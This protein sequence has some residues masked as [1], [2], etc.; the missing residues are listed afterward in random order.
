MRGWATVT[1]LGLAAGLAGW[2]GGAE[3]EAL[4]ERYCLEC[5]NASEQKG[6]LDLGGTAAVWSD[7]E[8]LENLEWVIAE[9]EMP[10][11]RS[12]QPTE[13][14]RAILGGWI[15]EKLAE[16]EEATKGDPGL[17]IMP[18]LNQA[19]YN[20]VIRD[21]TGHDLKPARFFPADQVAENGYA[22]M[23]AVL[24]VSPVHAENYLSAAKWV[25]EHALISPVRGVVWHPN[26]LETGSAEQIRETLLEEWYAWLAG[27]EA[28]QFGQGVSDG[29]DPDA[30]NV[31]EYLLAAWKYRFREE[32]GRPGWNFETL[33]EEAEGTMS[34][35]ILERWFGV[36]SESEEGLV[37]NYA[38]AWR[39]I[40]G[41]AAGD[42]GQAAE[43]C[44]VLEE[45]LLANLHPI[46]T[47]AWYQIGRVP[48][49]FRPEWEASQPNEPT[50]RP[51]ARYRSNGFPDWATDLLKRARYAADLDLEAFGGETLFLTV[52]DAWDG[53]AGDRVQLGDPRIE[54]ENGEVVSWA[55]AGLDVEWLRGGGA[56][57]ARIE[58]GAWL[59][60]PLV[61]R[62]ALP[63]G[64]RRLHAT[65]QLSDEKKR[66]ASVQ[67]VFTE[68]APEA[69]QQLYYPQRQ[70]LAWPENRKA[71]LESVQ[72]F[73]N[74]VARSTKIGGNE[75]S[76]ALAEVPGVDE[77]HLERLGAFTDNASFPE[78]VYF[79]DYE[80]LRRTM[81]PEER[82][83]TDDLIADL[84]FSAEPPFQQLERALRRGDDEGGPRGAQLLEA[85][86]LDSLDA[87]QRRKLA[88]V[89]REAAELEKSYRLHAAR[90]LKPFLR[91][92]FRRDVP[93]DEE[94]F[95]L[96]MYDVGRA[97]G[98]P[99]DGAVKRAM[100]I[101]MISP[102]FLFKM[103]NAD[104][105]IGIEPLKEFELASRLSFFLWSSAPDERLLDL[106]AEGKLRDPEVLIAEARRMLDDDRSLAL[107]E[108]FAGRWLGFHN[109]ADFSQPDMDRFPEFTESLRKA[110][111]L[112]SQRFFRHLFAEDRPLT[113]LIEAD[114]VFVNEELASHYGIEGV[115]GDEVRRVKLDP[116][117][118][119][120]R[121]GVFGM[122][123]LLTVTS[124]PL[125]SSPIYRGVWVI[126]RILGTAT[127][128]PP[129][130]VPTLSEDTQSADG[131]PIHEQLARH[132]ADPNCSVCHDRIDPPGLALETFDAIG[133]FRRTAPDGEP[134]FA[135]GQL[136]D[137]TVIEGLE[138]VRA[139]ATAQFD[140]LAR[141]FCEQL[142]IFGLG[143]ELTAGDRPLIAAMLE[144]AENAGWRST[145]PL[146]VLLT[147][148]QFLN[149][150]NTP[151]EADEI[152]VSTH[153][154][155]P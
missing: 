88:P 89:Q 124:T 149:R 122:G 112:E 154:K 146:E 74:L 19:E 11:R 116:D 130:A 63:P 103:Q 109:F 115:S 40:P 120:Q 82:R 151:R 70:V 114:Y 41:P 34:P 111:A 138:G 1:V 148:S 6:E 8:V 59:E 38:A 20:H 102:Q 147:S 144:A 66:E 7:H 123:S 46:Y 45:I 128:E 69:W 14:E 26:R 91:Q 139:Y 61:A 104:Q 47:G 18:R 100:V 62:I 25:T 64:A 5:H 153:E 32:L 108:E 9:G 31:D 125:R 22:N 95:F 13:E 127:P 141:H 39:S 83:H 4:L 16:L 140:Q 142:A 65:F 60:A 84:A 94:R 30:L 58:D 3:P 155:T 43:R 49:H 117:L 76:A 119:T 79:L 121:G 52:T 135:R 131:L 53:H 99:F 33:A 98:L 35:V 113:D 150:N 51:L 136:K 92:A 29:V 132:R 126:D 137:G 143:R 86:A 101:A 145:A 78:A 27:L 85:D 77:R 129:P 80:D 42:A 36:L 72:N 48:F 23:G 106:A 105:P 55:A 110:M 93:S 12:P 96:E 57:P 21:L 15:A 90:L 28:R 134:V 56:D 133:R 118:A 97:H 50:G 71:V 24:N 37:G 107:G 75:L 2:A 67:V 68:E 17:V 54:L 44:R 87:G 73:A 152:L 81:T 10:P